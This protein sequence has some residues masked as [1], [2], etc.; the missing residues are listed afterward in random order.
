MIWILNLSFGSK[1]N[2]PFHFIFP[3]TFGGAWIVSCSSETDGFSVSTVGYV[4]L[5]HLRHPTLSAGWVVCDFWEIWEFNLDVILYNVWAFLFLPL[6]SL[7]RFMALRSI[8]CWPGSSL[9]AWSLIIWLTYS[10]TLFTF[11][12]VIKKTCLWGDA[13]RLYTSCLHK[14]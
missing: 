2:F 5:N 11:S 10:S 8:G 12:F 3:W 13:L 9:S 4:S 7:I 6:V 1:V 14:N